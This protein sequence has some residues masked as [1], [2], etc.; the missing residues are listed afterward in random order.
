MSKRKLFCLAISTTVFLTSLIGCGQNNT[1]APVL[2][3]I[4]V[5]ATTSKTTYNYEEAFTLPVVTATYSNNTTKDVS[6]SC[7]Y[8]GFDSTIPGSQ[9][10]T[11]T[12]EES[13]VKKDTTYTVTIADPKSAL[14][15]A[16][17]ADVQLCN[18]TKIPGE[19]ET[20]LGGTTNAG[21][22]LTSHL[23]YCKDNDI[24]LIVMNGDITN[25]ANTYYYDYFERILKS[26][27]G[28]NEANYPEF[29]W[30]MGNH[31]WWW[32]T[33]EQ[34]P[35]F[36]T[37]DAV[38]L[39][40]SHARISSPN[41]IR[42][43]AVK[44]PRNN[45]STV[46][47][48]YK[49]INGIPFLNISG[50][51]SNGTISTELYTELE[52]WL[53]EIKQIDSVKKG[54]PIFVEYHYAL[55]TSM[56]HGQGQGPDSVTLETLLADTPNAVV[57]TGDTHY[58]GIN[59]RSI[60]Q[61]NFTTINLGSSSYS[62]M[63]Q[64]SAVVCDGYYN[65]D[66]NGS[67]ISDKMLDN[68]NFDYAYTPTIQVVDVSED[69][70]FTVDKYFTDIENPARKVGE[71]WRIPAI[72]SKANF[73]YTND[74]FQNQKASE[75]L[76]G[77]KGLSW[78]TTDEVRF[79]VDKVNNQMT[80]LFPDVSKYHFCEHYK[81]TVNG[82]KSYDVVSNY[83]KYCETKQDNYY[84][85]K[86]IPVAENYSVKVEAYDF[87][88]NVSL[89]ALTSSTNDDKAVVDPLDYQAVS[90]Y[91]D[92][93]T[94]N[95]FSEVS[96]ENSNSSIEY[97]YRGIELYK[98]GAILNR[99]IH[100]GGVDCSKFV[101][102]QTAEKC[103]PTVTVDVKN[104]VTGSLTVGLSVVIVDPDDSSKDKWLDDFSV[105]RTSVSGNEWTQVQWNLKKLFGIT[106][107]SEIK[108]IS[109]KASSSL[110][111]YD[112]YDMRLAIDN[113]D[114]LPKGTIKRNPVS[115]NGGEDCEIRLTN[116]KQQG[117]KLV[118]D[119]KCS[120][121]NINDAAYIA[122]M[123]DWDNYFGY[124]G[125]T[126]YG[127]VNDKKYEGVSVAVTDDGYVRATFDISSLKDMQNNPTKVTFIY[128]RGAWTTTGGL[129]E[130]DPDAGEII[131]GQQFGPDIEFTKD[132]AP[133]PIATGTF[134][135]DVKFTSDATTKIAMMLGDGWSNYL[136]YYNLN[137]E[138]TS[139]TYAGI[140]VRT[141]D[142]GYMRFTFTLSALTKIEGTPINVNLVYF[143]LN[144][145][146]TATGYCEI[147][148]T[149]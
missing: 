11:V 145:W 31:E 57:F 99:L 116:V 131:R 6:N 36:N 121:K 94:R 83:Y 105:T 78:E 123:D 111:S 51:N 142:D 144:G 72:K 136:G 34:E 69:H 45:N 39:F 22:A 122:L 19:A 2:S 102:L 59:E 20:N 106:S 76:Y 54:G 87:F 26:V 44:Y 100:K 89:N 148:P 139:E 103:E 3:K 9:T 14:K 16:I 71:T 91:S 70:S 109:L 114:L 48:Y 33:T 93:Q 90:T 42:E 86:D 43:S 143:R 55:S 138:T 77:A 56:T 119:V 120:S 37:N 38:A 112:G 12:Y 58:P 115:F 130:V 65:I 60:N 149:I 125:F 46:P 146:T 98:A 113:Y 147:N 110:A 133:I 88:D 15:F 104:L 66:G 107:L 28:T 53:N 141:L 17:F 108:M 24:K 134:V 81:I 47:T 82:S 96:G 27:Y 63:P 117:D 95:N 4:E 62:R 10:I 41:L 8:E 97:H 135:M 35:E 85:L 21:L 68:V 129:I 126:A 80:V 75:D 30:N 128:I 25:Q 124:F 13:Q 79:G 127:T 84:I 140:S 49:V 7:Q 32:G 132:I 29:V 61:V 50:I 74:R 92:I 5:D 52:N 73:T 137:C 40:K 1:P 67:K 18:D 23:Q 64:K 118:L 101:T